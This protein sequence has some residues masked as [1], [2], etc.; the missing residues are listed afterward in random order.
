MTTIAVY[1]SILGL[2]ARHP[3]LVKHSQCPRGGN[4]DQMVALGLLRWSSAG[5]GGREQTARVS[6]RN[7]RINYN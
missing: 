3:R 2:V 4:V 6:R 1:T 7:I 5:T